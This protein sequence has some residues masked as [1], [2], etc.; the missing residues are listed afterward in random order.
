MSVIA[1]LNVLLTASAGQY[2]A[3][4]TKAQ[5]TAKMT[6]TTMESA[7]MRASKAWTGLGKAAALIGVGLSLDRMRTGTMQILESVEA[8]DALAKRLGTSYNGLLSLQHAAEKNASSTEVMNTA[9]EKMTKVLGDA[10][11]G[12]QSAMESLDRLGLS[13]GRLQNMKPEEQFV[14]IMEGVRGLNTPM[15][16]ATA[17]QDLFGRGAG[18]LGSLVNMTADDL[19]QYRAELDR[20]GK[21]LDDAQL[22]KMLEA[23]DAVEGL[24]HA[25]DGFS[26][27]MTVQFAPAIIA[28]LEAVTKAMTKTSDETKSFGE[29]LQDTFMSVPMLNIY[30]EL[31]VK[32]NSDPMKD[33]R[34]T[35]RSAAT[36]AAGESSFENKTATWRPPSAISAGSNADAI[37]SFRSRMGGGAANP[38][39]QQVAIGKQQVQ[40]QQRMVRALEEQP[41]KAEF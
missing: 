3:T 40:L 35:P 16:R 23:Q 2:E 6:G 14:A 13:Y 27:Q 36:G 10:A 7:G 21:T 39:V 24:Q 17:L 34:P 29:T 19:R 38:A 5:R 32:D 9:L 31:G 30:K 1:S 25:W 18:E 20:T 28:A 22:S 33:K 26:T 8:N 12:E 37:F 15:E 4:M 41:R 11:F